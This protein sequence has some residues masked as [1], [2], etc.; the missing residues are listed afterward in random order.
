MIPENINIPELVSEVSDDGVAMGQR[1]GHESPGLEDGLISVLETAQDGDFGSAGI[2]VLD[3]TPAITSD[4]RDIAQ[5]VLTQSDVDT[6]I[7]RAPASAAVVSDVH[8]RAALEMGQHEL[9]GTTDY[10]LGTEL[11]IRD[12][13]ES[14][15]MDINWGQVTIWG[16]VAV[17]LVVIVSAV[18]VRRKAAQLP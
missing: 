16:L 13:T 6:V 14:G 2:V 4:L 12:V 1:I 9:L 10:V 11:L 8:S 3:D 5:E 17:T 18:S 7:V 15:L